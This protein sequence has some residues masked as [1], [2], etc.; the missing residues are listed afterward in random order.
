MNEMEEGR[1]EAIK[2]YKFAVLNMLRHVSMCSTADFMD[3]VNQVMKARND[4]LKYG[5]SLEEAMK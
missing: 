1:E 3:S 5:V 2:N 4:L